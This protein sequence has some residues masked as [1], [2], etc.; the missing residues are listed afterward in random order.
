MTSTTPARLLAR[1]EQEIDTRADEQNPDDQCPDTAQALAFANGE[2]A[3]ENFAAVQDIGTDTHKDQ[4]DDHQ[5]LIDASAS[6]LPDLRSSFTV[7]A[8]RNAIRSRPLASRLL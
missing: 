2:A 5:S 8:V 4:T 6:Q 1:L 3:E 7:L